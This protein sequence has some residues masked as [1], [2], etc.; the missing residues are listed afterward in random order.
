MESPILLLTAFLKSVAIGFASCCTPITELL[1]RSTVSVPPETS[2]MSTPPS[3][4]SKYLRIHVT[5][6]LVP[7]FNHI[8]SSIDIGRVTIKKTREIYMIN[9]KSTPNNFGVRQ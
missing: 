1:L 6:V 9:H 4:A 3:H 8:Y 7:P 5:L 2:D